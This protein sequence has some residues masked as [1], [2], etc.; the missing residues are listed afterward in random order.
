ML[1]MLCSHY[2]KPSYLLTLMG[3]M[4]GLGFATILALISSGYWA[5]LILGPCSS[6]LGHYPLPYILV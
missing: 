3:P 4:E 6:S 5:A 2:Y 1:R